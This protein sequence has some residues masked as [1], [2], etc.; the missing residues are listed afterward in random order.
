MVLEQGARLLLIFPRQ[1]SVRMSALS[2]ACNYRMCCSSGGLAR[3]LTGSLSLH[4]RQAHP[5]YSQSFRSH[6]T[7]DVNGSLV[8]NLSACP[9]VAPDRPFPHNRPTGGKVTSLGVLLGT[10]Q[11]H[12]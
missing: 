3:D 5:P 1:A 12:H 6:P 4:L 10:F 11:R 8:F 7:T 2:R 9:G